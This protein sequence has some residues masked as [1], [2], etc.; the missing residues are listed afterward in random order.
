MKLKTFNLCVGI[1]IGYFLVQAFKYLNT[2]F[3]W[4]LFYR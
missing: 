4:I 3:L 1:F 2:N